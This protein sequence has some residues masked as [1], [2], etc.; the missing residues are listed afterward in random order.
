MMLFHYLL[1]FISSLMFSMPHYFIDAA[2]A[3][4]AASLFRFTCYF[5]TL[6]ISF[7]RCQRR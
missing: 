3:A 7:L 4:D 6:M 2:F 5:A 1:I